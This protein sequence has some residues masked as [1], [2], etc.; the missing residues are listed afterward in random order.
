[1]C[2]C[3]WILVGGEEGEGRLSV[4]GWHRQRDGAPKLSGSK[5]IKQPVVTQQNHI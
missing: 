5:F 3:V 2:V 1:V 4:A